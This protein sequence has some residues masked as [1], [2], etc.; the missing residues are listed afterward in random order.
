MSTIHHTGRNRVYTVGVLSAALIVP[1]TYTV[2][3]RVYTS[4]LTG[5]IDDICVAFE[6]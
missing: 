4:W 5:Q 6:K 1:Y 2:E 3:G